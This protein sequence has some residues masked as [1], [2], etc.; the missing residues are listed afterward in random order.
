MSA[1]KVLYVYV[2]IHSLTH[3]EPAVHMALPPDNEH[4]GTPVYL[5]SHCPGQGQLLPALDLLL[6]GWLPSQQARCP[7][8]SQAFP[9]CFYHLPLEL[10]V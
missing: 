8:S 9:V 7:M 1:Y 3:G 5:C 10:N 4:E 2:F 6:T